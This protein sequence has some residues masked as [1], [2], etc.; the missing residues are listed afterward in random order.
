M[1]RSGLAELYSKCRVLLMKNDSLYTLSADPTGG[2]EEDETPLETTRLAP[3]PPDATL[4][5]PLTE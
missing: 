2:M 4:G 3:P 5:H 1:P